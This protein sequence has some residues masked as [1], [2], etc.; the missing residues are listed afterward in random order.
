MKFKYCLYRVSILFLFFLFSSH[1]SYSQKVPGLMDP[2][3]WSETCFDQMGSVDFTSRYLYNTSEASGYQL[4]ALAI[5]LVGDLDG[6]GYPEIV[7]LGANNNSLTQT[8]EYILIFNGQTGATISRI[9]LKRKDNGGR[10][11]FTN[12]YNW[13]GSPSNMA[14]INTKRSNSGLT[15]GESK[16]AELIIAFSD[17]TNTTA[18]RHA[19]VSYDLIKTTTGGYRMEE[20]WSKKY[21]DG[22]ATARFGKPLPQVLDFDGDGK[23]ELLVYNKIFDAETGAVKMTLGTVT[24]SEN[25]TTVH[26]GRD[27]GIYTNSTSDPYLNFSFTYDMDFDGTYDYVAGGQLWRKINFESSQYELITMAGVPDGRT[28]V[29]DIDGDGIPDIVVAKRTSSSNIRLIVWNPNVL[30]SDASGNITDNPSTPVP[31][32][33]ADVTVPMSIP[34]YG[35]NSYIYIGDID[36]REQVV[37]GKT[38]RLPEIAILAG[39]FH[40]TNG[41]RNFPRHPN[42]AADGVSIPTTPQST[43]YGDMIALTWDADPN[44]AKSSK[45]KLSFALEH[46]DNSGNTGFTLFDFDNDGIQEICYQDVE[47]IRIIKGNRPY[48]KW[49]DTQA[50]NP[51]IVFS[52]AIKNETGYQYPVIADVNNDSSA[53]MVII[54][55]N[56]GTA[57]Y[58][59]IKVLGTNGDKFAPALP[60]WNQFMYSPFKVNPDLTV[61]TPEERVTNPLQFKYARRVINADATIDTLYNFTP[62]NGSIVQGTKYTEI[63][64]A[65]DPDIKFYEPVIFLTEAYVCDANNPDVAKWP[66][67]YTNNSNKANIEITVGNNSTAQADVTINTPIMVYK[68][69]VSKDNLVLKT[70]LENLRRVDNNAYVNAAIKAGEEVRIVIPDLS[71]P[72]AVYIV[73]LGDDSDLSGATPVWKFG[74]NYDPLGEIS[75]PTKG[76]GIATRYFRD[77]NWNDQTLRVAQFLLEDDAAT[78]Q[79]FSAVVIPIVSNDILPVNFVT[80]LELNEDMITEQPKGGYIRFMGQGANSSVA[81]YHDGKTELTDGIDKFSYKFIYNDPKTGTK[82]ERSADVYIYILQSKTGSFAACYNTK[83]TVELKEA[84]SSV[85]FSW[86]DEDG[87]QIGQN[88]Q[89]SIIIDPITS[90]TQ[91]FVKPEVTSGAYRLVNFPKGSLTI[92]VINDSDDSKALMKWTGLVDNNWNNSGNWVE[93]KDGMEYPVLWAP[94]SCTDIIIPGEIVNYP[95]LTKPEMCSKIKLGNRAMIGGIHHLTYET[96]EVDFVLEYKERN[97]FVMWSAP[98]KSTYTGDYHFKGQ[99]NSPKWGDVYMSFFQSKNP[100]LPNSVAKENMFTS[101]FGDLETELPLGTAF[102]LKSTNWGKDA[103]FSF[104]QLSDK[105]QYAHDETKYTGVLDRTHSGRF[106]TDGVLTTNGEMDLPVNGDNDYAMIQVVNPFMSYLKVGDFLTE[107]NAIL[108]QAY[109][110]WNGKSDEDF[111]TVLSTMDEEGNKILLNDKFNLDDN[112][113]NTS[114][115][116]P[117][118]SFFVMKKAASPVTSLKMNSSMTTV[119]SEQPSYEL[120]S[121]VRENTESNVLRIRATQNDI[122]NSTIIYPVKDAVSGYDGGE[123]SRKLFNEGFPVSIYTLASSGEPLAINATGKFTERIPL[124][125]RLQNSGQVTL[126]FNSIENLGY[127]VYLID[128]KLNNKVIDLTMNSSYNFSV[129]KSLDSH[130]EINDRFSLY[131]EDNSS[132]NIHSY[133]NDNVIVIGDKGRISV[134]S[135]S[136]TIDEVYVYTTLGATIYQSTV[137]S[138]SFEIAVPSEQ[139]YIVKAKVGDKFK[140]V[141]VAVK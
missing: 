120:R 31:Y 141:K 37:D 102:I 67:I 16:N 6:D 27:Y 130:I 104:P 137:S 73:R 87:V 20:I 1:L 110:I 13:H 74:V 125:L 28:A 86:Y 124:G 114:L 127:D 68:D 54:G 76:I 112:D 85:Q 14:L 89:S 91:Y 128:H 98:L 101:S 81:Y 95:V 122:S 32:I 94:T 139:F 29:A 129:E 103:T 53:E 69:F 65:T 52:R 48:L 11:T 75:D 26:Y 61:P 118:Q 56:S 2:V 55:Q 79:E 46:R 92:K 7:A 8:Y 123:D 49:N 109:K 90:T 126:E 35:M 100:D 59:H 4:N 121:T 62:F 36:G 96:A 33:M 108:E 88:P 93:V 22:T 24:T 116:A 117:L 119:L 34:T 38:Y 39:D 58:G 140:I 138:N 57:Y 136:G 131:F 40:S 132:T 44:V 82:V 5:P 45:L 15:A 113:L 97:R 77:C 106:I 99:D 30:I 115:I 72:Y 78:L 63:P 70:K 19:V 71:D 111:I 84:P 107:N 25:T 43:R 133:D 83:H 51:S 60:V 80:D 42:L 23:A 17:E 21:Y 18:Y 134:Q 12:G 3:D 10:L 41:Y 9:P 50:T 47:Y 64:H 66:T 135:I 105:Y